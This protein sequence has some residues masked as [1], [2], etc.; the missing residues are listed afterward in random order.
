[1]DCRLTP[2]SCD[3]NASCVNSTV[4]IIARTD[5]NGNSLPTFH[6]HNCQCNSGYIGNGFICIEEPT[7]CL[8]TCCDSS[9]TYL[10]IEQEYCN[11]TTYDCPTTTTTTTTTT[12]KLF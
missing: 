11:C 10:V 4:Q 5:S 6:D 9:G 12:S 1:M 7:D 2:D 8:S 3:D